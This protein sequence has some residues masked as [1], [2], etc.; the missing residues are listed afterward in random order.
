MSAPR[1]LLFLVHRI[2]YPPDKG[3]K[4]RS[5]HL[6]QGLAS[7]YRVHLGSFVD[8]PQ[9]WAH[10]ETLRQWCAS[11]E[12]RP[13]VPWR[14]TLRSARGL[15]TGEPLTDPYYCDPVLHAWVKATLARESI[16]AIVVLSSSMAQYVPDARTRST[17]CVVDFGDVDSD[18]WLQYSV[19]ARWPMSWVYRREGLRLEQR[20]G[21]IARMSHASVFVSH[22]EAEHFRRL[23]PDTR[24]QVHAVPN[25]VDSATFSPAHP[26]DSPYSPDE[27]ALVFTGV[28]DY[29][30]N[31]DAVTWFARDVLPAIR[32]SEPRA[33]FW[34]VGS[35][36]TA[37]VRALATLDGV[38]VA[39]RV[40]D[41]RPFLRHAAFAVAPLRLARGV[42]N[43]VLEAMAMARP[44]LATSAATR[45]IDAATPPGV[46]I[47][48][49]AE[50]L[51]HEALALLDAPDREA[52]GA[53]ARR[54]VTERFD[55]DA[56]QRAF[57]ALLA[58]RSGGS[59]LRIHD[60]GRS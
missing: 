16:E 30:A 51:A 27:R 59:L 55:W 43:K 38:T 33:R 2:P 31:V 8:N 57:L 17:R 15:F 45:G 3:D 13:L 18:K 60:G 26:F 48:D 28:M 49:T 42:Q 35:N 25:G 14:A 19:D 39:G 12:L 22:A 56:S 50:S 46:V 52:R 37:A 1:D 10:A 32:A 47:A 34:I 40:P 24:Q 41:V 29:R 5:F 6:L 53:A 23:H 44:V 20:E 36:P 58:E 7:Q 9:D 11:L 21:H 4:I 54:Y